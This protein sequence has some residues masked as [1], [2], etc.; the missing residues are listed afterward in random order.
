MANK[1]RCTIAAITVLLKNNKEIWMHGGLHEFTRDADWVER[2][3]DANGIIF[4]WQDVN[5]NVYHKTLVSKQIE[6]DQL[7][8][9]PL[10][11]SL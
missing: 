8:N 11:G 1:R 10:E 2:L 4:V 5:N 6:R 3:T 9:L 7:K